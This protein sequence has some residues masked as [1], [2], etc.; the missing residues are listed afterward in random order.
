MTV[1]RHQILGALLGAGALLLCG[2]FGSLAKRL[3]D[4]ETYPIIEQKQIQALGKARPFSIDLTTSTLTQRILAQAGTTSDLSTTGGLAISLSDALAIAI[5]NSAGYQSRKEQLYLSALRLTED[6]RAFSPIFS[7]ALAARAT[8][9]PSGATAA[10]RLREL[11]GDFALSWLLP[12]GAR[13]TAG[14][15]SNLVHTV[16]GPRAQGSGSFAASIVQPLLQGAGTLATLENLR[17]GE[18][19]VIYAVRDF[20]RF[21][22]AFVVG[23]VTEYFRVLQA[24]NTIDNES[25]TYQR[26]IVARQRAEAMLEANRMAQV[27]VDQALQNEIRAR[28][29]WISAQT[30]YRQQL[31]GFKA[32]LGLPAELNIRPDPRELEKLQQDG[33]LDLTLTLPAAEQLAQERRLDLMTAREQ[34]ADT[35]RRLAI[36]ENGLLPALDVRA[37][38]N[39]PQMSGNQPFTFDWRR[40][41]Y[42]TGLDLDLPLDRK[43]ER[44]DYR[45]ALIDAQAAEREARQLRNDIIV[46][47]RRAYQNVLEARQSYEIQEEGLT[48]AER[49]VDNVAMLLA[50]GRTGL[51]IRDQLEAEAA[52]LEARIALTRALVDY[53]VA[54]LQFFDAT[55]S[56]EIDDR[57]MWDETV[58]QP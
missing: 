40:R 24:A 3:A 7:G 36:A 46:E 9:E 55:E 5:D 53:T 14:L 21:R 34:V 19:D 27:E 47:V 8:R 43:A 32:T 44:N 29:R 2:C 50:A 31:D 35:E 10:S 26:L 22:K 18:R 38:L 11:A 15:S 33:L 37:N 58:T 30:D 1:T 42:G 4:R 28:N 51:N 17:Q 54:R 45:R 25:L 6:R 13:I 20:A 57:G 39:V 41:S 49:R 12:T 16:T 56:L 23:R 52:L 48:L